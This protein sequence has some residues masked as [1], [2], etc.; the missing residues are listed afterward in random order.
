MSTSQTDTARSDHPR[1]LDPFETALLAEL[2]REVATRAAQ[3][4]PTSRPS[5]RRPPW[6]AGAASV[7]AVGAAF[8]VVTALAATPD[9]APSDGVAAQP[10][11]TQTERLRPAAF[12][13]RT[14]AD[15]DV[16]VAIRRFEDAAGLEA[17][18]AEHGIDAEVAFDADRP[19]GEPALPD[20]APD[21]GPVLPYV[22]VDPADPEAGGSLGVNEPGNVY[23]PGPGD[24]VAGDVGPLDPYGC[25]LDAAAGLSHEGGVWR[26]R[27]PAGSPLRDRPIEIVTAGDARIGVSY[28]GT[29]AG[30]RCAVV[31][32]TAPR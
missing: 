4:T 29:R 7:A 19:A 6:W 31:P 13:V 9:R 22:P 32:V 3:A 24:P 23:S 18:L 10:G 12:T 15:D 21:A 26:L 17:A 16:V 2:R 28:P 11:V 20:S 30:T 8:A 25:G 14:D 5:R 1:G 27:I